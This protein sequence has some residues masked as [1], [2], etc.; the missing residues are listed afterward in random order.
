MR[1][2]LA[3]ASGAIG[4]PL[5]RQ[6]HAAGHEV[7]A[8]HKSPWGRD[9][10][11]AAGAAPIQVDVL[12]GAGLLA[13]L[14]GQRAD[15]VISELTALKKTPT[16]H[17]DMAAT[18]QLRTEGTANLIAAARQLG[19]RRFLT[20]SMVLGY[21]YGDWGGRVLTEADPF[22]PPGH[23]RFEEHLAAMR[24]N[25]QQVFTAGSLDGVALRYGFLYG[26]GPASDAIIDGLRKRK[27]PIVRG[28]RV[29]PG[30]MS[31]T[32]PQPP[33]PL[34]NA[35]SRVPPTTSPTIA[36]QLRH[37]A[38][39]PRRRHRGTPPA[40]RARLA[41]RR[42]PLRQG[43]HRRR[44]AAIQRQSHRRTRLDT[45]GTHLPRGHQPPHPLPRP[46][47]LNRLA[48]AA[49]ADM[50][51]RPERASRQQRGCDSQ[52]PWIVLFE[53]A[54]VCGLGSQ[55]EPAGQ[56]PGDE[57]HDSDDKDRRA[58]ADQVNRDRVTSQRAAGDVRRCTGRVAHAP[59]AAAVP[60]GVRRVP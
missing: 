24:A 36:G 13:A 35:A 40:G 56:L 44:A 45:P 25:E 50:P 26:P 54:G 18:N 3:G 8:I 15:A 31:M 28:A 22:A 51:R 16:A 58:D 57:Q 6:L 2:L 43:P 34:S 9:R 37:R 55:H 47:N 10:L 23:G 52:T 42:R 14:D 48:R 19:A 7:I 53:R 39:R 38:H 12:D 41:A 20:Q 59:T 17:K 1:V 33:P 4:M 27:I 46:G 30:S 32:P 49:A 5:I 11:A 60:A 29:Q 21:G